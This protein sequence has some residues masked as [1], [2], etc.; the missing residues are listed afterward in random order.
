[1]FVTVNHHVGL[2]EGIVHEMAHHKLRA[3][4]VEME[5][6]S[7]LLLNLPTEVYKSPIRYDCLR[8]MTAVLHA[9]YSYTYIAQFDLKILQQ[10]GDMPRALAIRER[11]LAVILPKL[12]HGLR[13]I[14]SHARTDD[15]GARFVESFLAWCGR[16][17]AAGYADLQASGV[18][19]QA[20]RHP[21]A[22]T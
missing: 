15:D 8:P 21:I 19:A 10:D 18:H 2:A 7:R 6:S 3:I 20:F 9:Q 14:A 17:I 13:T 16:I 11:S 1:V 12:E 5:S 4:G 22:S